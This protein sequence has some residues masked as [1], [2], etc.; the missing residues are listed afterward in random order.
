MMITEWGLAS[1]CSEDD[2][3]WMRAHIPLKEHMYNSDRMH[4]GVVL[5]LESGRANIVKYIAEYYPKR[6]EEL[7]SAYLFGYYF[8]KACQEGD[9]VWLQ[10]NINKIKVG[11]FYSFRTQNN[12]YYKSYNYDQKAGLYEAVH[13]GH[14][15]LAEFLVSKIPELKEMYL[16]ECFFKACNEGDIIW[17]QENFE[18]MQ[19]HQ[20]KQ[21]AEGLGKA[22]TG[23][24]DTLARYI[25]SKKP[26]LESLF[27]QALFFRACQEGDLHWIQGNIQQL[28]LFGVDIERCLRYAI[29]F[30]HDDIFMFIVKNTTKMSKVTSGDIA[31][32]MHKMCGLAAGKGNLSIL[33]YI[34]EEAPLLGYPVIDCL[35][36][37]INIKWREYY[38]KISVTDKAVIK[39]LKNIHKI[40]KLVGFEDGF[41]QVLEI[42]VNTYLAGI[43]AKK[44]LPASLSGRPQ[45]K[46]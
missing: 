39:Y 17:V 28:A 2:I 36:W 16:L 44:K 43:R 25:V 30:G 42:G 46:F 12:N 18:A 35:F 13:A 20:I 37:R 45:I 4:E 19:N 40:Q 11:R 22:A 8:I 34:I 33:R 27:V 41:R 31:T 26:E 32:C 21:I 9:L 7:Y 5:A 10:E 29:E 3:N 6:R 14:Y 38:A 15:S 24:H 23:K 1:D